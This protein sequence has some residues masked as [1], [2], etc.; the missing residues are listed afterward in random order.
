MKNIKK[1][2]DLL[3]PA[4]DIVCGVCGRC[5]EGLCPSSVEIVPTKGGYEIKATWREAIK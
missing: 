4:M 3:G 2:M 5:K 1:E